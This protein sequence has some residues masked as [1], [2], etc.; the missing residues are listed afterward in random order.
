MDLPE[1]YEKVK[2]KIPADLKGVQRVTLTM[3]GWTS[4]AQYSNLEVT[5]HYFK[6]GK[7]ESAVLDCSVLAEGGSATKIAERAREIIDEWNF[8]QSPWHCHR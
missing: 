5:A 3:D 6:S 1:L 4:R 8:R 2:G 7:L